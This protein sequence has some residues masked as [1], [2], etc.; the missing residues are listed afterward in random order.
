[1][2][3]QYLAGL[4]R[5][6]EH[7]EEKWYWAVHLSDEAEIHAAYDYLSLCSRGNGLSR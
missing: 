6:V 3:E 7:A 2:R 1:M 5:R 4:V